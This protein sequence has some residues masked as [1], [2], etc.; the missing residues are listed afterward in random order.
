VTHDRAEALSIGDEVAVMRNGRIEQVGAPRD[1]YTRPATPAIAEFVADA[2]V[3]DAAITG[4]I[5]TTPFGSVEV[6]VGSPVDGVGPALAVIRP[7]QVGVEVLDAGGSVGRVTRAE[8]FGHGARIEIAVPIADREIALRA[9]VPAGT[10]L[11]EGSTVAI[12]ISGAVWCL[13]AP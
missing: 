1:L 8:Y 12:E 9:R 3:V 7:D 2:T 4:R 13:P 11:E 5:A 10:L 6:A